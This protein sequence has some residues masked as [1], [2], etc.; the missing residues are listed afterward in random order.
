[1]LATKHIGVGIGAVLLLGLATVFAGHDVDSGEKQPIIGRWDLTVQGSDGEYPSWIEI[2]RSGHKTLVGRYVG[3]FGSARPISRVDVENN[4]F[5]FTVPPQWES[6]KEDVTVEGQLD[7]D[8]LRGQTTD[9]KGQR[10]TWTGRRAPSLKRTHAP[11]WGEPIEL[12]NGKDLTGWKPRSSQ[13]KNG[14]TVRDG[15]LVNANPGNDLVTEQKFNDF[16]IHAEYRY[17]SGSNSGLYLRGR[18][19]VQI[20]DDYGKEEDSHGSAGI[21]GFLTP[22]LN[23]VKKPGEWQTIDVTLI[24]REVTVRLNG[25][26]VIERQA[27]PG[28]TGGAL[29]SDEG[30]PGPIM[31]QGDHGP[32]E[33]RKLTLTPGN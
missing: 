3:E 10:V 21:Y 8:T 24:G 33:F 12:I 31:V 22:R 7:G 14:W 27:I 17:P 30:A 26:D 18:Y 32:I 29:D 5:R 16:K 4:R 2:Q 1:M 20:E 15:V 28:I 6:R 23:A 11:T 19:E 13:A 25:E 9:E